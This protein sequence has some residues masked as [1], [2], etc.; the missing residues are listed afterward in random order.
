MATTSMIG[1]AIRQRRGHEATPE[2]VPMSA[3][4]YRPGPNYGGM[5]IDGVLYRV[6]RQMVWEGRYDG[7][8]TIRTEPATLR[9]VNKCDTCHRS[10]VREVIA[11][12]VAE[13]VGFGWL[14]PDVPPVGA[15]P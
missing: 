11:Y 2:T 9:A 12:S 8:V 5:T 3:P 15:R 6:R 4:P 14:V 7:D 10:D 1:W 13:A